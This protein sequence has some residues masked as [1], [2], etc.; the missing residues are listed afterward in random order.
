MSQSPLFVV[1]GHRRFGACMLHALNNIPS[2]FHYCFLNETFAGSAPFFLPIFL[3][4][5]LPILF[6]ASS[7]SST[8]HWP[9]PRYS[10]SPRMTPARKLPSAALSSGT[11]ALSTSASVSSSRPSL[12]GFGLS[13]RLEKAASWLQRP[14]QPNPSGTTAGQSLHAQ[15][16]THSHQGTL[17]HHLAAAPFSTSGPSQRS[18]SSSS[19][20]E[21]DLYQVQDLNWNGGNRTIVLV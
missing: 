2:F 5:Q 13:A 11:R 15:P 8:R 21:D 10:H 7:L 14:S 6:V 3:A 19:K 12:L 4:P 1:P 17:P 18:R 9:S 20:E 16:S